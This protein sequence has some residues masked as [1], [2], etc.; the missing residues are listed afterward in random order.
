[1]ARIIE[2]DATGFVL[3]SSLLLAGFKK[4]NEHEKEND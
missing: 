4:E 1:V 3:V 2:T